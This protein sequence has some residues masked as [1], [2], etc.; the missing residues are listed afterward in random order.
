M[1]YGAGPQV[2]DDISF[3]LEP[4]SFHYLAGP[5]GAGKSSLL[6]LLYLGHRPSSGRMTMFGHDIGALPRRALPALRRRIGVVFQD[7]RLIDHLTVF[8]NVALPLRIRG[9]RERRIAE[10]VGELLAW[11]GLGGRLHDYPPTL[12]G[13]EKQRAAI[14]RAVIVRPRL[15]LA[16]EP[17]GS[18]DPEAGDRLVR[19]FDELNRIG[20]T[21]LIATHMAH[22][23]ARSG[24][25]V[26]YLEGGRLGA[27]RRYG[28][29]A[30]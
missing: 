24:H 6:R 25:P 10:N 13:G 29:V 14:A 28:A 15:L 26:L 12:S 2:L 11:V 30:V 4:A 20:T 16:D 1:R 19:L 9:A 7:F 21:V 17:T 27:P 5:S 23:A 22:L 18:V 3:T 8:D